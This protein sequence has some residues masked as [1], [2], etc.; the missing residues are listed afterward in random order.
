MVLVQAFNGA[1]DTR[2]PMLINLCCYW[3]F[4]LPLA[5]TLAVLLHWGP[6]GIFAAVPAT[7]TLGT[8]SSFILFR[9]GKW[10]L[11]VI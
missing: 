4:Q 2:T 9:R 6:M 1:G 3:G 5:W 7:E 11:K 8:I 10:K